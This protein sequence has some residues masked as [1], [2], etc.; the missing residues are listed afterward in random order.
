VPIEKSRTEQQIDG[1]PAG[2]GDACLDFFRLF[3]DVN[4][5]GQIGRHIAQ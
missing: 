2:V 5:Q 3:G 4:V 1:P